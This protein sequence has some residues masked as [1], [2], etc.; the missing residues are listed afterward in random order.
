MTSGLV[1]GDVG[2]DFNNARIDKNQSEALY[3]K[4]TKNASLRVELWSV[5]GV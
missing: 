5:Q 2:I 4:L 1:F 3:C